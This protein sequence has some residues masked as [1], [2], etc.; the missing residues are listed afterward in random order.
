[1]ER[2]ARAAVWLVPFSL[3][4]MTLVAVPLHLLDDAG[5]PRYR[6]LQQ[7]LGEVKHD[8]DRMRQKVRELQREVRALR[9]DPTEVERIARDELGMIRDDEIIFQ[10]PE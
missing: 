5:L 3:L 8:N 1:M 4:V 10:F 2:F 6:A 7:E 9:T